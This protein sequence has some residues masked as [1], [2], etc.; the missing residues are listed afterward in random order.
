MATF[1]CKMC[2][3]D[4][5]VQDG[6]CVVECGYCGTKQTVSATDDEKRVNLY[7]R[8]NHLRMNS[9]FDKAAG[10]Y[11]Q[12]V[13]EFPN[14]AEA[15][16]GLCLCNYGVEYVDDPATG[17]KIPTIHRAS[18]EKMRKDENYER[19]LE[20]AD[21]A[22]RLVYQEQAKE[23]DRIM[24]E[25]L[26]ISQDEKPYDIFICYKETDEV[27]GRTVDSVIAQN[28][29][30]ALTDKGYKVFFSRITLEDKLGKQ[31]EPYIF[32]ALNSAKVMLA[33]G[34]DYEYYNAVW[35]KNEWRRFWKLAAADKSKV[36]IPCYKDMDAYDFPNEFKGL[37]AQ[38]MGKVGAMQDLLR[39]ID[40]IFGRDKKPAAAP[41]VSAAPTVAPLLERSFM[42]LEDGE[43]VKADALLEQVLNQDPKNAQAYLGKL[44]AELNV[45]KPD[46]LKDCAKPFDESDNYKKAVRF[47]D[48]KLEAEMR[49][50]ITHI[51]ERIENE[52]LTGIYNSA[53]NA[54]NAADTE[55]AFKSAA[56]KFRQISTHKNAAEMAEQC[57]QKAEV[58]R[59]ERLMSLYRRAVQTMESAKGAQDYRTAANRFG[60]VIDFQDSKERMEQCLQKAEV[61]RKD[62]FYDAAKASM[63]GE[64][65]TAYETAIKDFQKIPGWKDADEQ[66]V[67]CQKKIE[68][69]KAKEEADRIEAERKAEEE[70]L[71]AERKAEER[72]LAAEAAKKKAKKIALIASPIVVACVIFVIVL[73]T[74]IIPKQKFNK[75]MSLLDSGD[76]DSAY[77]LLEE[78]GNS[79]AI[80]SSK[81][82][83]AIKLIDSGDYEP[84]YM[85][86]NGLEY[87]DSDEKVNE[88]LAEHPNYKLR[89]AAIGE[90]V[91]FGAYEQ[92]NNTSNGKEAIEWTVLDKD[93]MSLLLVSK[94]ALDC[95]RYNT[96]YTDVTWE[97]CS[98]RKWMN[99]TFL[100][101]A[102]SAE[103][104]SQIQNTNVSADKNPEYS[105]NPG[106][107]TTDKVFLLSITEA[108]KYFT[109]DESRVC[110]PTAY[111][112]SRGAWTSDSYKTASGEATCWWWLRSPGDTQYFA[113]SVNC[114]GSVGDGGHPVYIADDCV[115]P[116]MWINLS[117]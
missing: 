26:A 77:A 34:T 48:E 61:C 100:N 76:Y 38:D 50:Y 98:L 23:I 20:N 33:V 94:Y 68:E 116:A 75:A 4:L 96:S 52:R 70:R 30:D 40:K 64:E 8:A 9:E 57:L 104:Q 110:A 115:R 102:F 6:A 69:I 41:V 31:Y 95:Q 99:G 66:I 109:S 37:Q 88:I 62:G 42:F 1:K 80:A 3:G 78:I 87:K 10:L 65:I 111:A 5:D 105:T 59:N 17:N 112:M 84:A 45:Q 83:R 107:A 85:L 35:V 11:E 2:G 46:G 101:N 14:D 27:G 43:W 39:G 81:Y 90:I 51:N 56:A 25:V 16:W 12:I 22:A 55:D 113:T 103:E 13:A 21:I 79:D 24:G 29:Y 67:A 36:L 92:D 91:T 73:T 44:L 106:N 18:F 63:T 58:C 28:I 15:Y 86:L 32:A 108:E 72:R 74:V 114:V 82:D 19:A 71:E 89:F 93:G 60:E 49:G 53:K 54:M 47:G 97:S 7:N 117:K